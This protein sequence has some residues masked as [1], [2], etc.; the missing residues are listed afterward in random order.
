MLR[1]DGAFA[2][3]ILIFIVSLAPTAKSAEPPLSFRE[4]VAPILVKNCL[5]CHNDK[6]AEHGLNL[7]TFALLKKGGK[8]S[9]EGVLVAGKA[10]ESELVQSVLEDASPRMPFKLPPISNDE[11]NTLTRWVNEGAKF[12]GGSEAETPIASLVDPLK[13]LPSITM[14][15]KVLD[16]VNALAFSPDGAILAAAIGREV[17]VFDRA[18]GK[19]TTRLP[20]DLGIVNAVLFSADGRLMI[21]AGGRAGMFGAFAGWESSG[22]KRVFA[23]KG[24]NDAILAAAISPDGKTLATASY[25]RLVLLW[26]L[27]AD[28]KIRA[29]LKDHTDAVHAVSFR[30]DGTGLVTAGADRTAKIWDAATNLRLKTLSD[31]KAELQAAAFGLDPQTVIAGGV[32]R[33][34]RLWQINGPDAALTHS[35]FAHDG[36]ILNLAVVPGTKVVVTGGEDRAV[37]VWDLESLT[38]RRTFA[39]QSDWPQAIAADP[40]GKALA[41]GRADGSLSLVELETGKSIKELRSLPVPTT[42]PSPPKLARNATLNPP[43]PRGGAR[44]TTTRLTLTGEGV[45]RAVSVVLPESDIS[46]AIVA[47]TPTDPNRLEVD[48]TIDPKARVGLHSLAVITPQGTTPSQTFAVEARPAVAETEPNA[49]NESAKKVTIPAT[50]VG[51]IDQPGDRDLFQIDVRK[52][53]LLTIAATTKSLGSMITA[54]LTIRD[55]NGVVIAATQPGTNLDAGDPILSAV[56]PGDGALTLEVTDADFGGSAAHFYRLALGREAMLNTIAPLGVAS[57]HPTPV[58]VGGVGLAPLSEVVVTPPAGTKPGT[59]IE[60]PL[61]LSDGSR[62]LRP[63]SVVVVEGPQK[64]EAEPNDSPA[65]LELVETPSGTSGTISNDGDVDHFGFVAKKGE[66]LIVEVYGRRLGSPVDP[67]IEILN[68]RGEPLPRAL[69]R[70]LSE[71]EVAFRDH[72]ATTTG[73]RLTRWDGL[74]INDILM[75]GREVG[76]IASL[77]RSA[78]DDCQFWSEEGQRSGW[79]ETTPEYHALSEAIYKVEV[80]HPTAKLPSG[81]K[82]PVTLFYRNDDGGPT[83]RKDARLTFDPPADGRYL[84]KVGDSRGLGGE[85]FAYHL[86]IRKPSPDFKVNLSTENPNIPRGGTTL[87]TA[88]INRV[89]GF[90]SPVDLTVENLPAGITA[91]TARIEPNTNSAILA[92]TAAPS[93]QAYSAPTWKVTATAGA[94]LKQEIDPGGPRGGW[95]TVTPEP[96]HKV[97]LIPSRVTI[98]PGQDVTMKIKVERGPAFSG[99]VPIKVLNLPV[100]VQVSNL[101]LNGVLVR[102]DETE[103]AITLHAEPWVTAAERPFFA[104]G[105]AESAATEH[106]SVASTLVVEPIPT[107]VSR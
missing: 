10:D 1:L 24:P 63:K 86:V 74:A 2:I 104:V 88:T 51:T 12:D 23:T 71:T 35:A 30:R 19:E 8:T 37:K 56:A 38:L 44:G 33:T 67:A 93:A 4:K 6:K 46:A 54:L 27:G 61:V 34:L 3:L 85:A 40:A 36:A 76:R 29:T 47:T 42:P 22:F 17:V 60:V 94:S 95:I 7:S 64:M 102:E 97:T 16:P 103:R 101:G 78:D 58:K 107:S 13:D 69:L 80:L 100:G 26:N 79:L 96:N 82:A 77:P 89:D 25:D 65:G 43:Q 99:R 32:D 90:D 87:V 5:G 31:S 39:N 59:L 66:R 81:S 49:T 84:V 14:T 41:I 21:A 75:I 57:N 11:I 91:T 20:A 50:L 68:D 98:H 53:E 105:R 55:A 72:N 73:I 28:P 52:G 62:P 83:F 9:G 18:T 106:A 45:G 15:A 48:L 92:L 70:P